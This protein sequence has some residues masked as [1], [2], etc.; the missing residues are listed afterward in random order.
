[1]LMTWFVMEKR[2]EQRRQDRLCSGMTLIEIL[3]VIMISSIVLTVVT[4]ALA[5]GFPVS[6]RALFQAQATGTARVQ[7]KRI[8]K[9]LREARES[10]V[11]SYPL[12][13]AENKKIVFYSDVDHDTDVERIRYELVGTNLER[14]VIKPS[15]NPIRYREVDEETAVV[16]SSV[17]NENVSDVFTYYSG[18]YP[19][20]PAPL[21]PS[22]LTEVKYIQFNL[23][24]D[25]NPLIDPEPIN[26]ISQ[27][28]IRNLKTNLGEIVQ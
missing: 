20:D 6:K 2:S 8:A 23:L 13:E 17:R 15:G 27:V 26:L 21:S 5:T 28:Q 3:V 25:V 14:G 19:A 16:A 11:G 4:R 1:M 10:D 18:D 9:A 24:I 7:L 22:D 12:V